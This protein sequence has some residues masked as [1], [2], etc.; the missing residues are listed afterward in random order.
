MTT[1]TKSGKLLYQV[2]RLV[3]K[4]FRQR[5][6][7]GNGGWIWNTQG[8]DRALYH[9]P[10]VLKANTVCVT[11]GEKDADNLCEAWIHSYVQQRW[12]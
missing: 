3:P 4:D 2:C 11:E 7:D 8:V 9:L 12:S 1:P 5:R 6:P 10:E